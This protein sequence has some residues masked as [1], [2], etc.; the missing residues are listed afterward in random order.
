MR[1]LVL[2]DVHANL[3]ALHAVLTH[4]RI[5]GWDHVLV[6]GDIIGYG[7]DPN[8]VVEEIRA[9]S[10]RAIV[11]G[12]HDK[13]GT[14]LE[15]A[16][17]FNPSARAAIAWTQHALTPEHTQWVCGLPMGPV[18]VDEA[19]TICHGAPFDEDAYLE[20]ERDYRRASTHVTAPVCFFGH[21]HVPV[22]WHSAE[23]QTPLR[24]PG[25][26]IDVQVL[27]VCRGGWLINPGSVGQPRDGDPRAAYGLFDAAART[28]TLVRVPYDV[29]AAQEKIRE[30]RLP[31][32][33]ALRLALGH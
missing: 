12:N 5:A 20:D 24:W 32:R 15:P 11:R 19:C 22:A 16:S 31:E 13:V 28:V 2:S 6:L 27:D 4:A 10:A 9:L 23:G 33:L 25:S 1:Y 29:Q 26:G 18:T 3:E 7:A 30:A 21:T 8:A 17:G 14:G